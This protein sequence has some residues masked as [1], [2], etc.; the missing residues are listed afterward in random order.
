MDSEL[1]IDMDEAAKLFDENSIK[2]GL[3][4][5]T[6]SISTNRKNRSKSPTITKNK[7][8]KKSEAKKKKKKVIT[9][10]ENIEKDSSE[11]DMDKSVNKDKNEEEKNIEEE[12]KDETV[13]KKD[14]DK[15]SK[16]EK[17][18]NNDKKNNK[19]K[20]KS[21]AKA[22]EPKENQSANQNDKKDKKK[23]KGKK[24][25]TSEG[26]GE[27]IDTTQITK[28]DGKSKV[29]GKSKDKSKVKKKEEPK[30]DDPKQYVYDYMKSQNRPYSLVNIFDNLH[31]AIKK[32]LLGKILD[33]LVEDGS[34]IM[35][36]YNSKI[37]LFNQDKLDIKV[38]DADI[39]QIQKEIDEKR[40]E[41]KA[42]KEEITSKSNELKILTSALTDDELKARI[43][44]LKKELAKIK[45]K[46][47]Y[48]GLFLGENIVYSETKEPKKIFNT[49]LKTG[50]NYETNKNKFSK[51]NAHYTQIIW[52]N[53]KE[54]GISMS[55]DKE[56]KKYCTVVLYNPPGNT[57]GSFHENI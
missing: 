54:I 52:K 27:S 37:Y 50:N 49:W 8:N 3:K 15:S 34:L 21:E 56:T 14:N 43:K 42:L 5:N 19:K 44:E 17:A 55:Y 35:K 2:D 48:N 10:D 38:T 51:E 36:E 40:E 25:K 26:E 29:K 16:N 30:I 31:G 18:D 46:V 45:V 57:L 47:M 28:N 24:K 7:K 39:E 32:S 33:A 12:T 20:K 11:L 4:S 41:N 9:D 1:N 23:G 53:T 22:E 13:E 6:K